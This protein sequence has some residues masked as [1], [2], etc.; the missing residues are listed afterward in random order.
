MKRIS[1]LL[2]TVLSITFVQ[3]Q[4]EDGF[5]NI[6]TP[7][8]IDLEANAHLEDVKVKKKKRKKRVFYGVKTRKAYT[9]TGFGDKTTYE[10]FHILKVHQDPDQY[11]RDIYWYDSRR[12][13]I[14]TGGKFDPKYGTIL[15]GPYVK[16]Q[17]TQVLEEGIFHFG[18]KHGRWV[19]LDKNDILLDK[20]K[21]YKGWPKE[22]LVK[23]YGSDRTKFKEV[24]PVE[25]G[26]KEG[27]YFYFFEN[28]MIAVR[29]EYKYGQ[30]VG[31]W[32]EFH[33]NSQRRK[34][35]IQYP[36]NPYDKDSR[37]YVWREYNK[38]GKLV[39]ENKT[40]GKK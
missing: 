33:H 8:T 25:Y 10:L 34:K 16:K 2:L 22:S 23:Y 14:R 19:T 36:K 5:E 12:G 1:L 4:D 9:K 18:T 30:K 39:Y 21:Y 24:V 29:G 31:R 28:G 7:L 32:M 15:H 13:S 35:I 27:N 17:G 6:N 38:K 3:A 26:E 40:K 20:T 37:P 11:V